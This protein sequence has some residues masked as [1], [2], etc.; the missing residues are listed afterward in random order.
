MLYEKIKSYSKEKK[1][2]ISKI[3]EMIGV[4]PGSICKWAKSNPSYDKVVKVAKIFGVTVE[5]LTE[6]TVEIKK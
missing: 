6:G 3:E 4:V 2:P 1:I 5:E